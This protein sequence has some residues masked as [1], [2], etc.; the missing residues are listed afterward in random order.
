ME[1]S[2]IFMNYFLPFLIPQILDSSKLKEFADNNSKFDENGRE[3]SKSVENNVGKGEIARYKQFLL[4][5]QCFQ[6][7]LSEDTWKPG[8]VWERVKVTKHL[9]GETTG[10]SQSEVVI[11]SKSTI[12]QEWR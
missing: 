5:P 9:I 12:K 11:L 8:L 6:K 3:F 10:F 7:T 4:F 2:L 1:L